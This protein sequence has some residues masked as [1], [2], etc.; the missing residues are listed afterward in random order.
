MPDVLNRPDCLSMFGQFTRRHGIEGE[1]RR[2]F[3]S[4]ERGSSVIYPMA[5][6]LRLLLDLAVVGEDRIFALEALSADRFFVHLAGGAIPRLDTAR[7]APQCAER[8]THPR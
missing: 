4:L 3:G 5:E 7:S 6:Q 2:R 8:C 1:L